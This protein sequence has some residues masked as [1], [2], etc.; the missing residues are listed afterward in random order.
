MIELA[1]NAR[2]G[3]VE[4]VS[5]FDADLL[6]P[7]PPTRPEP[8]DG[9]SADDFERRAEAFAAEAKRY[10]EETL[11]AWQRAL[12]VASETGNWTEVLRPDAKPTTFVCRQIPGDEWERVKAVVLN[13][14][15]ET[16]GI[17]VRLALV[18]VRGPWIAG[19]RVPDA[20]PIVLVDSAT[21]GPLH[22]GLRGAPA[23]MLRTF[24]AALP[25]EAAG[26][27]ISDLGL[28]IYRHRQARPG[29]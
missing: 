15:S 27:V 9:E 8:A 22:T 10:A 19:F 24:Y 18:E 2:V 17:L 13:R 29:N 7:P 21:G 4:F 28:Q 5:S 3:H 6:V 1:S 26:D 20:K 16:F 23:D 12:R 11:P 14:G 25:G